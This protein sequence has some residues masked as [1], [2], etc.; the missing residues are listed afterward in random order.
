MRINSGQ[1]GDL[2][3]EK[4][5]PRS[6]YEIVRNEIT[7]AMVLAGIDALG[8]MEDKRAAGAHVTPGDIACAVYSAMR[9]IA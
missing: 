6:V 9:S 7:T 3:I 4:R 2:P 8:E 5:V 1:A